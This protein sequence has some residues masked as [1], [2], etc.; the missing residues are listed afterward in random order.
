MP[1][2][3]M[4]SNLCYL[5][6]PQLG[7]KCREYT[8]NGFHKTLIYIEAHILLNLLKELGKSDKMRGLLS[9]KLLFRNEFNKLLFLKEF[10]QFNNTEHKCQIL[11]IT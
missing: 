4:A 10:D 7:L 3:V 6:H 2:R 1:L 9:I 11:F 5:S 8:S